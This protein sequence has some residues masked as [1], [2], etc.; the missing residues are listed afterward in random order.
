MVVTGWHHAGPVTPHCVT[1]PS[2]RTGLVDLK[3]PQANDH[4]KGNLMLIGLCGRPGS[5]RDLVTSYLTSA[6]HTFLTVTF[7]APLRHMI[8]ACAGISDAQFD[9]ARRNDV[10]PTLGKS[11][12]Q[13]LNALR[14]SWI[15]ARMDP[16]VLV[17]HC[18][19]AL[20]QLDGCDVVVPDVATHAE[21][22]FIHARG[23]R[24]IR[25]VS[26]HGYDV[27]PLIRPQLFDFQ[28]RVSD[29][30]SGLYEELDA[31]VGKKAFAEAGA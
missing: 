20:D 5:G 3:H 11:P 4:D 7:D 29:K 26:E 19:E 16:E 31:I 13:L 10:V 6:N 8:Q 17:N 24:L 12:V 14:E 18:A 2:P 15:R 22:E 30:C 27:E 9:A 21:A 28:L 1:A 23:G 25:L